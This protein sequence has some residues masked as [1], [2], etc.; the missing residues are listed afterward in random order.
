MGSLFVGCCDAFE[1]EHVRPNPG[2]T[3]IVG[4]QVYSE[5]PDRRKRY[6][7]VVGVDMLAGPGVDRVLNLEEKLPSDLGRFAHVECMSVLEHSKRPW[8][9]AANIERLLKPGGTIYVTVPLCWRV[10]AYPD[11]YW[12][13]TPSA[14]QSIF[15]GVE[16][17]ALAIGYGDQVRAPGS[18]IRALKRGGIPY[19]PRTETLG[20]G[21]RQ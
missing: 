8:L 13:M 2:R 5:K 11:D 12:R 18:R 7:D 1:A 15:P 21:R 6:E 10:H 20:F 14:L 3:L 19:F 4:S 9:M 16:W 17:E